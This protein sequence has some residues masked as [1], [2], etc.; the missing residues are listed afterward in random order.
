MTERTMLT[1]GYCKC[2]KCCSWERTW[3]GTPVH[4]SGPKKGQRKKIGQT[5]CGEQASHGTIAADSR[6]RFGTVMYVPGYGYGRVEDRGGGINGNHID[7]YFKTHEAAKKW[8]KQTKRVKIW[9]RA[10]RR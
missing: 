5:A 8:G 10:S 7:L 4:S 3:A 2:G 9:S 1:T 6:Y